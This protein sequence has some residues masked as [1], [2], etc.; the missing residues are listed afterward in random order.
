MRDVK[1]ELRKDHSGPIPI[2][3][4]GHQLW[5]ITAGH[6]TTITGP[7]VE[8]EKWEESLILNR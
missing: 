2:T 1:R 7:D 8:S 3:V 5:G 6:K 4:T